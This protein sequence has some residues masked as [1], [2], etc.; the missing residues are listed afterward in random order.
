LATTG[1]GGKGVLIVWAA[2]NEAESLDIDE[3]ASSPWVLAAGSVDEN[4]RHADYSDFGN[5]LDLCAASSATI[6]PDGV[7]PML[8]TTTNQGGFA[9]DF[10]ANSGSAAIV[11]GAAALVQSMKPSATAAEVRRA[12][13][14]TCVKVSPA[15][16]QYDSSG[17]S[18]RYGHGRIDAAAAC[19]AV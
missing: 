3:W 16:A 12:I 10:G 5:A 14:T 19:A 18:A 13:E 4:D 1:R 8:A 7:H 2:G 15:D 11:S 17:F 9:D 6:L